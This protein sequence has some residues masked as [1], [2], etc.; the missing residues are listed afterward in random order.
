MLPIVEIVW[1]TNTPL[2]HSD[3]FCGS[4]GKELLKTM[5]EKEKML[6]TN[7]F[8]YYRMFSY[9]RKTYATRY[10]KRDLIGTPR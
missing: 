7:I 8:S 9:L 2:P 6:V 1:K 3:D 4:R 10:A 5:G